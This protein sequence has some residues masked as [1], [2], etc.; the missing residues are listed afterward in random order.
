M[1]LWSGFLRT[2]GILNGCGTSGI[3][4]ARGGRQQLC[5]EAYIDMH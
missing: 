4:K 5:L 3:S 2:N 1:S